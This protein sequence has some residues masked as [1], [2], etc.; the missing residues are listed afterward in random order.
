MYLVFL[1]L[2]ILLN[3]QLTGEIVCFGIVIAGAMYAFFCKFMD[4]SIE[5]DIL[6]LRKLPLILLY[7]LVLFWEIIKA[8]VSA[9]RLTLSYRNE[10]D[11]V[12]VQFQTGLKTDLANVVLANSI[13][14]TPG[15]ITV[16]M[17]EDELTVHA[18]DVSLAAGMDDSVFVHMLRRMEA[19]DD[20]MLKKRGKRHV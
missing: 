19:I 1:L 3:G 2:W 14:L 17:E 5:K 8:N 20:E 12:I 18:L 15:T 7:I 13:T 10:I 4:Y 6:L 11:P 9:I 16:A